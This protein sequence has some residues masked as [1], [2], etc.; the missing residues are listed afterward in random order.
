MEGSSALY[1]GVKVLTI[2]IF[3]GSL[4]DPRVKNFVGLGEEERLMVCIA[5]I[6]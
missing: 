3:R 2:K 4:P 6:E 5:G 1:L